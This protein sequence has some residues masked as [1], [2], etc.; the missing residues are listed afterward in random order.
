MPSSPQQRRLGIYDLIPT[1]PL[2][3]GKP[4]PPILCSRQ[5]LPNVT[6]LVVKTTESDRKV[7]GSTYRETKDRGF[8]HG[9]LLLNTDLSCLANYLKPDK[10]KL[11]A[12]GITSV[13]SRVAKLT[14]LLLGITHERIFAA[15]TEAFFEHYSECV[16]AEVISPDK[17]PDLLNFAETFS[18][19]S[20]WEWNFG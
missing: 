20:S 13:R 2:M 7:S 4:S 14:E 9:T 3:A 12:K 8:H 10:K 16:E 18:H 5:K 19:Q 15:V 6:C 17:T 11:A 1:L